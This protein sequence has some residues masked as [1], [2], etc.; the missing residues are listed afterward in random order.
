MKLPV[1]LPATTGSRACQP[2]A[3]CHVRGQ[4]VPGAGDCCG[5]GSGVRPSWPALPAMGIYC[6]PGC[7]MLPLLSAVAAVADGA[8]QRR[9]LRSATAASA[10]ALAC[11]E[12]YC[13]C[14]W[15]CCAAA[16]SLRRGADA[17]SGWTQSWNSCAL[18]RAERAGDA[19]APVRAAV[20][21]EG[22][23]RRQ[24]RSQ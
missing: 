17:A 10:S 11:R 16:P 6:C 13:C 9:L 20:G 18:D 21:W 5:G 2:A 14:C 22:S 23:N 8:V 15:C 7:D 24:T 19:Q 12:C 1:R 3:S 4:E